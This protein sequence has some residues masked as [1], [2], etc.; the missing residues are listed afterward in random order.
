[1]NYK[2]NAKLILIMWHILTLWFE[3]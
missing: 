3:T 1:M 2:K